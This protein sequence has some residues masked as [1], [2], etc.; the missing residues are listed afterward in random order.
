M[1]A[2]IVLLHKIILPEQMEWLR[3][4]LYRTDKDDNAL[5]SKDPP[6]KASLYVLRHSAIEILRT[7]QSE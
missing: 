7:H 4:D 5:C 3:A 1:P 2:R 6:E